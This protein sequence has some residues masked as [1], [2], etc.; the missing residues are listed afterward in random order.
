MK[1][2]LIE[3]LKR[4]GR[5]HVDA[6]ETVA[7]L[8]MPDKVKSPAE[9]YSVSLADIRA[10]AGGHEWRADLPKGFESEAPSTLAEFAEVLSEVP[11]KKAKG[12]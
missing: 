10:P 12:K 7:D 4:L 11:A 3:A 8:L 9:M 1:H 5:G 6:A 2:D